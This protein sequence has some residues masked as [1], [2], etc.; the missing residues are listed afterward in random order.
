MPIRQVAWYIAVDGIHDVRGC[1]GKHRTH[2]GV[3]KIVE[4]TLR[5]ALRVLL[6]CGRGLSSLARCTTVGRLWRL[7]PGNGFFLNEK[8]C[9]LLSQLDT[10]RVK[11]VHGTSTTGYDVLV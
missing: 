2:P 10:R 3:C 1:H 8:D 9:M 4:V 6:Y 11:I 5:N 7:P